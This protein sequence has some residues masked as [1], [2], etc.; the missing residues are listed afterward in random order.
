MLSRKVEFHRDTNIVIPY[1]IPG[2]PKIRVFEA[3]NK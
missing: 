2:F 3:T 1:G